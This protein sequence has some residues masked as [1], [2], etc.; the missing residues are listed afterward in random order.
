MGFK[1][2]DERT[3]EAAREAV[4]IP[5]MTPEMTRDMGEVVVPV[6]DNVPEEPVFEWDRDNPDM[7]VGVCYP[8]MDDFRLA[9]RQH[10]IV[11][12]FE[13][14]TAHSDTQRFRGHCGSLGCP[15]IIRAR[16]QHDGSVRVH[17]LAIFL[18]FSVCKCSLFHQLITYAS[19]CCDFAGANK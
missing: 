15:W 1:A 13:L 16:T 6:D 14:A 12:E 5:T 19:V 9:M 4:P 17:F 3:K 11:K 18:T 7:S 2:A 8:S 10:A